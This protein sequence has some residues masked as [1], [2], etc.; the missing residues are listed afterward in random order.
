MKNISSSSNPIIKN[1]KSLYRK[2]ERWNKKL[3]LIEGVKIVGECIESGIEPIY[4]L[5]SDVLFSTT[6]GERLFNKIKRYDEKLVKLP[7]K[8]LKD[9]SDTENPQGILA[10][11]K[12][13]ILELDILFKMKDK[14]FIIL[15]ELQDPGNMG[16]IIRTADAFGASGV[17]VTSNCVDIYNPKVVRSTM[18]S[19]FHVPIV[20]IEDKLQIINKLKSKK[21]QV[22]ATSLESANY[23][24]DVNFKRDFAL[25]IGNESKGVSEEILALADGTIKIPIIGN[26]ESL[27][28][29]IASSIIMYEAVRQRS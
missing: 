2:K 11:V 15:D 5:F 17:V 1:A 4:I 28:A 12:F 26:A 20:Y 18:G 23:I 13:N 29:A 24:Y 9:I 3:F 8:L 10:I 14:F 22:Y 6:G 21:I 19:L 25:I 16:T 27:N 7:N